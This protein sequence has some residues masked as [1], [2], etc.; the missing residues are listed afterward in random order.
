M[1]DKLLNSGF[2]KPFF[3]L[4]VLMFGVLAVGSVVFAEGSSP[5]V[6]LEDFQH[7]DE[8]AFPQGWEGS[9]SKVTAKVAYSIH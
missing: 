1:N 5:G 6:V 8:D 3:L 9:R 2:T 4:L 7:P